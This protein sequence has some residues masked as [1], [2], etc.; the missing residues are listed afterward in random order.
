MLR[1]SALLQEPRCKSMVKDNLAKTVKDLKQEIVKAYE[2]G[3]TIVEAERL[4][5][6]TLHARLLLSDEIKVIDLDAKM[7]RNGVKSVRANAYMEELSKHDKKPAEGFLEN[8]VNLNQEVL[9]EEISFFEVESERN[10]L[11]SYL[12]IFKDAHLYFRQICKG[13]F[14]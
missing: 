5:A 3:V 4:A 1:W 10:R 6:L 11:E 7:R 13:T 12:D 2:Q 9:N 14:E 8:A